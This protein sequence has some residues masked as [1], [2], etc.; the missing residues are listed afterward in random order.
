MFRTMLDA[1]YT[2]KTE[3]D[4]FCKVYTRMFGK[5]GEMK[6]NLIF[7]TTMDSFYKANASYLKSCKGTV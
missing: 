6:H 2:C 4:F 7:F 3:D 5:S 1:L